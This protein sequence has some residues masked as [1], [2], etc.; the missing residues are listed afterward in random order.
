ML[1]KAY[2]DGDTDKCMELCMQEG[3]ECDE[4]LLILAECCIKK[5]YEY[6]KSGKLRQ[7]LKASESA[8]KYGSKSLYSSDSIRFKSDIL[9]V[10]A[11]CV[12]PNIKQDKRKEQDVEIYKEYYMEISGQKEYYTKSIEATKMIERGDYA[13]AV[14]QIREILKK[15]YL[16]VPFVYGLYCDLETCYRELKDYENAYNYSQKAKKIFGNM[17]Q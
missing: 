7:A 10:M 15:K 6:Y 3:T 9:E 13:D 11:S 5:A 12:F 17:Q 4:A 1:K 8:V 16:D 14:V 2:A